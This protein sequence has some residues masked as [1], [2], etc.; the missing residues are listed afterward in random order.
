MNGYYSQYGED[1][2]IEAILGD[3]IGKLLEIGAWHPTQLSN[4]RR[5]IEK[6]WSAV[7]VDFCPSAVRA[8]VGEYG[9]NE[10]VQILQAAVSMG[11]N[12]TLCRFT[13]SDD[14]ISSSSDAFVEKWSKTS[15]YVGRLWVP[16][17]SVQH[18]F[19]QFGSGYDFISI[20]TEGSSADLAIHL[21][22]DA[23]QEPKVICVEHDS[24]VVEIMQALQVFGY[25][26]HY[27]NGTNAILVKS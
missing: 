5:F 12:G 17:L 7:L 1:K 4:S 14:A 25:Y 18:L 10:K 2:I 9:N 27:T 11:D 20:D 26:V 22:R 3:K 16:L 21:V 19:H 15:G 23:R 13:V 8:L 6:G 24:R